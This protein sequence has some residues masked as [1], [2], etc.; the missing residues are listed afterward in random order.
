M[1]R[2]EKTETDPAHKT[3]SAELSSSK[4]P[5]GFHWLGANFFNPLVNSMC[6]EPANAITSTLEKATGQARKQH[7]EPLPV[8]ATSPERMSAEIV[9]QSAACAVGSV[10]PYALA[11]RLSGN[12][13]RF[14]GASLKTEGA[15]ANLAQNEKVAQIIGGGVY[16][17]MKETHA[18]ETHLRNGL[19]GAANFA[20]LEY[21]KINPKSSFIGRASDRFFAGAFGTFAHVAVSRPDVLPLDSQ[22]KINMPQRL[23]T[24]GLMNVLLPGTQEGI[25]LLQDKATLKMGL[26]VPIDRYLQ[27]NKVNTSFEASKPNDGKLFEKNRWARVEPNSMFDSYVSGRDMV[28][29]RNGSSRDTLFHELQHRKEALTGIAEPGFA[30]A[31]SLLDKSADRAWETYSSVR[32]AQEIRAELASRHSDVSNKAALVENLKRTIPFS[33]AAGGVPYITIW[34]VEFK[35]FMRSGGKYR[36]EADYSHCRS[37]REIREEANKLHFRL[38]GRQP[39]AERVIDDVIDRHDLKDGQVIEVFKHVNDFLNSRTDNVIQLPLDRLAMQT[40]R[41]TANPEKV[42]QGVNPTCGPAALEYCTYVKYPENAVNLISQ[43]ARTGK[44]QCAD[45]SSIVMNGLNIVPELHWNRRFANQLFQTAAVNVHWQ[46]KSDLEPWLSAADGVD[47][48]ILPGTVRYQRQ[49]TDPAS[50]I[51]Y[52][53]IDYSKKPPAPVHDRLRKE[54]QDDLSDPLMDCDSLNDIHGQ[55]N[56]GAAGDIALPWRLHSQQVLER[57]LRSRQLAGRLPIITVVDCRHPLFRY[58]LDTLP[59]SGW[60][61]VAVRSYDSKTKVASLFNPWGDV[62]EGVST[63]E[64][65]KAN[66]EFKATAEKKSL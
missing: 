35:E 24:G 27:S 43:V 21:W 28:T 56:G 8:P 11:G 23:L 29:L 19:A 3:D 41:L 6:V 53:L 47:N 31:A 30:R 46:R 60:H 2:F 16:D 18:G 20:V 59:E 34:R 36:P 9:C 5:D 64:L 58:G 15:L 50:M 33:S 61:F 65:Y 25:R 42:V 66:K 38:S 63:K 57:S 4:Q 40:L 10:V 32:L 54:L 55:I 44:F 1:P 17:G 45:G 49:T 13:M 37:N 62:L 7:I 26:G 51:P 39:H 22:V 48:S 14:A 12:V 52:R